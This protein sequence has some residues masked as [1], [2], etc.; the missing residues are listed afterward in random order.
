MITGLAKGLK[1]I[2]FDFSLGWSALW[3][4]EVDFLLFSRVPLREGSAVSSELYV[5]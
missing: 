5:S 2:S 3:I 1:A 4:R